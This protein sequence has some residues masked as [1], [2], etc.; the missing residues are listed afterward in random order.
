[1]PYT[2]RDAFHR[3][4]REFKESLPSCTKRTWMNYRGCLE[5]A[6]SIIGQGKEPHSVTA[7]EMAQITLGMKGNQ[8][9]R[10]IRLRIVRQFLRFCGN[11]DAMRP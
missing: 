11:K 10:A 2:E 4:L 6:W 3:H 9:T 5:E 7:A 8:N 1:M